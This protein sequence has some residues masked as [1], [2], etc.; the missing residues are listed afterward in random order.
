MK[1]Y[2]GPGREIGWNEFSSVALI[3]FFFK[4]FDVSLELGRIVPTFAN[5]DEWFTTSMIY[6]FDFHCRSS[7]SQYLLNGNRFI[8]LRLDNKPGKQFIWKL[9][10]FSTNRK[11]NY[12]RSRLGWFFLLDFFRL[13]RFIFLSST[14]SPVFLILSRPPSSISPL[15][16]LFSLKYNSK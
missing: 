2:F 16:S 9:R 12:A 13:P 4:H 1:E 7:I 5:T 14:L 15:F 10:S 11:A 3:Y 6:L 8:W